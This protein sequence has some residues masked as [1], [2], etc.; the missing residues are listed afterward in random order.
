MRSPNL[1]ALDNYFWSPLKDKVFSHPRPRNLAKL[2]RKIICSGERLNNHHGD[3]ICSGV[4]ETLTL[5]KQVIA[6]GGDYIQNFNW[7]P[8]FYVP[9][10]LL[11]HNHIYLFSH[12]VNNNN[13]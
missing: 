1:S 6:I 4:L 11:N 10:T 5:T 2:R 9:S 13:A 7:F 12:L 3:Q 8:L